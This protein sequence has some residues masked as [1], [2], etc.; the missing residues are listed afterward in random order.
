[1]QKDNTTKLLFVGVAIL[2]ISL[3]RLAP[4]APNFTAIGAMAIFGGAT[5]KNKW[6]AFSIPVIWYVVDRFIYQ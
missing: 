3:T 5:L 1:M 4:H 2:L 6:M